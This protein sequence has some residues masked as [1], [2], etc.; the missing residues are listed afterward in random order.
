MVLRIKKTRKFLGS[1]RWGAGNIKNA[2]GA[3]DRGG[4]GK[5][6]RKHKMTFLNVYDKESLIHKGFAPLKRRE[7]MIMDLTA[8]SK[9]AAS[10]QEPKPTLELKGYKVLGDGKLTKPM[11]I[12]ADGFSKSAERKIKEAGGEAVKF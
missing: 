11:V 6:G 10:M 4:V 2:R 12:K 8:I 7:L 1:R 9:K 5:G 3:G